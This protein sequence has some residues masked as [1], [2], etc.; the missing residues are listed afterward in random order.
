MATFEE[1]LL[2]ILNECQED[3]IKMQFN[4]TVS[5]L[6]IPYTA[7]LI[8][9]V[10]EWQKIK[11]I[12]VNY[13]KC[14]NPIMFDPHIM[15]KGTYTKYFDELLK[16]NEQIYGEGST[17][18]NYVAAIFKEIETAVPLTGQILDLSL[19]LGRLD[20]KRGTDWRATFPWLAKIVDA[21][22]PGTEKFLPPPKVHEIRPI[23][24]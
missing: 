6:S 1:N 9:K 15:P 22:P 18:K 5:T 3:N 2:Y 7:N 19:F 13:N 14:I 21:L 17:Y 20:K 23:K 16:L 24:L 10:I 12:E 8:R 11:H 4:L